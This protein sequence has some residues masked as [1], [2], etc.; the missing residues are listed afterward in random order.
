MLEIEDANRILFGRPQGK[1][2]LET[3]VDER[4]LL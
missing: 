4:I 1:Q 3:S 2:P